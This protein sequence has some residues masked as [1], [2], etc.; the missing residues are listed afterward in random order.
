HQFFACSNNSQDPD[1]SHPHIF[2]PNS[3]RL[4]NSQTRVSSTQCAITGLVLQAMGKKLLVYCSRQSTASME[5]Q[6]I[7]IC[8]IE[9]A[10]GGGV[11]LN[12]ITNLTLT[13]TRPRCLKVN[14]PRKAPHPFFV[15]SEMRSG[16]SII[17][18]SSA[19]KRVNRFSD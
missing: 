17:C 5:R 4:F 19:I 7:I 9:V 13:E 1:R 14:K 10:C 18:S 11:P 6:A 16:K 12:Q 8:Q 3:S 2:T 15:T